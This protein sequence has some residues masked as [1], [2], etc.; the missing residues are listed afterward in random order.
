MGSLNSVVRV[1]AGRLLVDMARAGAGRLSGGEEAR[2]FFQSGRDQQRPSSDAVMGQG[3]A[4]GDNE[5]EEEDEEFDYNDIDDDATSSVAPSEVASVCTV[6]T[7]TGMDPDVA[8][9]VSGC[10]IAQTSNIILLSLL[11]SFILETHFWSYWQNFLI[12]YW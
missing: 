7:T 12:L 10:H 2:E 5:K 11:S 3:D 1:V 8:E 6:I 9:K 4:D